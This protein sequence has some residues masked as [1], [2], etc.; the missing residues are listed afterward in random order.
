MSFETFVIW[1]ED[2]ESL[3]KK[4]NKV[5][6]IELLVNLSAIDIRWIVAS[7][8]IYKAASATASKASRWALKIFKDLTKLNHEFD[9][10]LSRI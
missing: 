7:R 5:C 10:L 4:P 6:W 3:S 1:C 9:S 2:T 8:S